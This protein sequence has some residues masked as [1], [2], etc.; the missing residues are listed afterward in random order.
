LAA[1][2]TRDFH[3]VD[4]DICQAKCIGTASVIGSSEKRK[5]KE[6]ERIK[7]T[8]SKETMNNIG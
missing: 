2:P 5:R 8:A 7:L 1:Y 3:L 4:S 6:N